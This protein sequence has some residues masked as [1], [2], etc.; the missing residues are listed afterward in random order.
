[1]TDTSY[2]PDYDFAQEIEDELRNIRQEATDGAMFGGL[3]N[4]HG[5]G[6]GSD[7]LVS[8]GQN[9]LL[10]EE[11]QG[12]PSAAPAAFGVYK[13]G[14]G[15]RLESIARAHYGEDNWRAGLA[16]MMIS[17]NIRRNHLGSPLIYAGRTLVVPELAD[18]EP[19]LDQLGG[20][21][22]AANAQGMEVWRHRQ[23]E[24]ARHDPVGDHQAPK[25]IEK[26]GDFVGHDPR[27]EALAG[28]IAESLGRG[29]GLGRGAW[30]TGKDIFNGLGFVARL[31]EPVT[32]P[33]VNPLAPILGRYVP[34]MRPDYSA[35]RELGE[36]GQQAVGYVVDR[37]VHPAKILDDMR[38]GVHKFNVSMNPRATPEAATFP[39][40]MDR[41][42]GIGANQGE[43]GFN[44]AST[45]A[46]GALLKGAN[47]PAMIARASEAAAGRAGRVALSDLARAYLDRPY[48]GIGH[49]TAPRRWKWVPR[50]YSDSP[51]NLL[52]PEGLT[53][54]QFYTLHRLVDRRFNHARLARGLPEKS[55]NGK[56]LG[57][58]PLNLPGRL[59]YGTTQ[60]LKNVVATPLLA[61]VALPEDAEDLQPD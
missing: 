47:V 19:E 39:E 15:D 51:L 27:R 60:P 45:V 9:P 37:S 6:P 49:H 1:M 28:I 30:N 3:A 46:G 24:Q 8:N 10:V 44:V 16:A 34:S 52:K 38:E 13:V 54:E 18:H 50:L 7:K 31:A 40:E 57:Y 12:N 32:Q 56:K 55:W 33:L 25:W 36:A 5:F 21:I 42:F 43:L 58:Q 11:A 61:G 48:D 29:Y 41:R 22:I 17:N 4:W 2:S 14:R 59:W 26:V 20:E 53:Q 35:W 23:A